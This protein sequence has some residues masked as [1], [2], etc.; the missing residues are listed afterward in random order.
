MLYNC[1]VSDK[2]GKLLGCVFEIYKKTTP[3]K[4]NLMFFND[5]R[6]SKRILHLDRQK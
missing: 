6:I 5:N 4:Y 1:Y 3:T 2:H